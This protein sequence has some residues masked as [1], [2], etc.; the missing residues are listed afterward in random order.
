MEQKPT[1][2]FAVERGAREDLLHG[3]R[4]AF[5]GGSFDPPH[6]GHLAV[7]R[8]AR[9]LLRLDEVLFVPV[10]RQPLKIGLGAAYEDRCAMTR[11][12]IEGEPEFS[13]SMIDA[14]HAEDAP[15]YTAETLEALQGMMSKGGKLFCLMGADSLLALDHWHRGAEIP[16]LA[17]VIV[18]SRPGEAL[19]PLGEHLPMGLKLAVEE[20][21]KLENGRLERWKI[22]DQGGRAAL[23][24]ILPGLH[25]EVSATELRTAIQTGRGSEQLMPHAV[26]AYIH[27]HGIYT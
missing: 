18:A 22:V 1:N 14:P 7:A 10:G 24:N 17:E 16:F 9:E 13:V 20:P 11:I 15:N 6:I 8:A 19:E 26:L 25:N 27:N 12:A 4:V 2:R 5:F 23:L 3:R 21:E